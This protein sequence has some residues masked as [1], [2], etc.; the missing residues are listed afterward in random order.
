MEVAPHHVGRAPVTAAGR[1]DGPRPTRLILKPGGFAALDETANRLG[2]DLGSASTGAS[3]PADA[4]D[5]L[6]TSLRQTNALR[7]LSGLDAHAAVASAGRDR[8]TPSYSGPLTVGSART[9]TMW[10]LSE[11][12]SLQ[13]AS[14]DEPR[15]R[16][17]LRRRAAARLILLVLIAVP[18]LTLGVQRDGIYR[19][20]TTPSESSE[21]GARPAAAPQA[22][23]VGSVGER[24]FGWAAVPHAV[25][26]DVRF[27]RNGRQIFAAR[28]SSPRLVLPVAWRYRGKR[29]VLRPGRYT[30]TVQPLFPG[31]RGPAVIQAAFVLK[32]G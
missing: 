13:P 27:S 28:P 11:L 6:Q 16:Q 26:Y 23:M 12:P 5:E 3:G 24:A 30:W 22:N 19:P 2:R 9:G 14:V 4:T 20:V 8:G 29:I 7:L 31:R 21:S 1:T 10:D 25:G 15:R 32:A 18:A 17:R